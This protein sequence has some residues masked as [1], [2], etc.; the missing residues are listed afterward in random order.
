MHKRR[1]ECSSWR[2]M[3][4]SV[5]KLS[6]HAVVLEWNNDPSWLDAIAWKQNSM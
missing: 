5:Q 4:A 3:G 1:Q 2:T 6:G